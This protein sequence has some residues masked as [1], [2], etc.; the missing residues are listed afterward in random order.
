MMYRARV[1]L[2][3]WVVMLL[4]APAAAQSPVGWRVDGAGR[5]ADANPPQ[6][7]SRRDN[8]QWMTELHRSNAGPVLVGGRLY[9]CA[10]PDRVVCLDASDGAI[11]WDRPAGLTELTDDP[12]VLAR[13]EKAPRFHKTLRGLD[14]RHAALRK[15][16]KKL[17]DKADK[18]PDDP[19]VAAPDP[20]EIERLAQQVEQAK[21]ERDAYRET[22]QPYEPYFPPPTHRTNGYTSP[23]PIADGRRV[24]AVNGYGIAS[25]FNAEGELLWIRH[26]DR[27]TNGW[28]VSPSPVMAG[29][30]MVVQLHKLY[31]LDPHTGEVVWTTNS[32]LR[33][34]TPAVVNAGGTDYIFTTEG[35]LVRAADG[36]K[37]AQLDKPAATVFSAPVGLGDTVYTV[38]DDQYVTAVRVQREAD[39]AVT[40]DRLFQTEVHKQRYYASLLVTEEL[41][42]A[43]ARDGVVSVLDRL[44][45]ELLGSEKLKLRG[46]IYSSPTLAGGYVYLAAER[47]EMAVFKLLDAP[48]PAADTSEADAVVIGGRLKLLETNRLR[49]TRACPVFAGPRMYVRT[50]RA[51]YCI[52]E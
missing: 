14:R 2:A 36:Q 9:T 20:A 4:M 51:V 25:C 24:W 10:E 6:T 38:A 45:G 23:T 8:V 30:R 22:A 35:T 46:T 15:Q 49:A 26:L 1:G 18:A 27:P 16:L 7:W 48:A 5:F 39:G 34:G 13:I 37:V 31:G 11:L 19:N 12:N 21:A 42:I 47:E 44:T 50:D 3:C 29:G 33:Y 41:V 52:S 32:K 40:L 17:R 28:G 43:A